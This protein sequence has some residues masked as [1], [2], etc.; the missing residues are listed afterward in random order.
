MVW[1][2][3]LLSASIVGFIMLGVIGTLMIYKKEKV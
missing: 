1:S 3:I 2:E